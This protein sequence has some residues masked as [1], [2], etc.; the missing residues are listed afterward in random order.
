[1]DME[2]I[3]RRQQPISK[4]TG[5]STAKPESCLDPSRRH[6]NWNLLKIG[7]AHFSACVIN[8]Q[9]LNDEEW[10]LLEFKITQTRYPLVERFLDL[11][12]AVVTQVMNI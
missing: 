1:M 8:V 9:I 5:L 11:L 2:Y 6:I 7:G 3:S 12:S 4:V 10:K